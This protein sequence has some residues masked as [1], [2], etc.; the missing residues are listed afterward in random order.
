MPLPPT[1]KVAGTLALKDGKE[2]KDAKNARLFGIEIVSKEVIA[3]HK[4]LSAVSE[5]YRNYFDYNSFD[6]AG[7]SIVAAVDLSRLLSID[8]FGFKNNAAW[9]P[10]EKMFMFGAGSENLSGF[11][12]ALDVVAHEFTVES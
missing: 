4:N 11:A 1:R 3:A 7:A 10:S 8:L 5:Y 2:T 9:L 12:G 6:N